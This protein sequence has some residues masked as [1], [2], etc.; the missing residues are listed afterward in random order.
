MQEAKPMYSVIIPTYNEASKPEDMENNL[1][2]IVNYFRKIEQSFEIIIV[3]DGPTDGTPELVREKTKDLEN[4]KIIDRKKN[5]GKGYSVREGMLAAEGKIRMFTDMDGAT[6]IEMFDRFL[7]E[8]DKG[9][10]IVIASRDL[11]EAEVKVH[12]PKW[13]EFLGD[14]GNIAIQMMTG[15]WGIKDTQCGFKALTDEAVEDV[16]PRMV[17]DTW[18]TDFEILMIGKKRG[19]KIAEVPVEW[20]DKGDS[21]VGLSGYFE[22]LRDL[23]K[24]KK[25]MIFGVYELDKAVEE[26]KK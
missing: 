5:K 12:Q 8:F 4:I 11:K 6:P 21:L 24:V 23:L 13:K 7:P 14:T 16:F 25:N 9:A 1:N 3:L 20:I 2:S 15:L 17:V 22:T 19:Y 26:I 10:E 18:G